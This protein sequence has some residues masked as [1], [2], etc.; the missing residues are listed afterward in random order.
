MI[1]SLF[2]RLRV[3]QFPEVSFTPSLIDGVFFCW[4]QKWPLFLFRANNQL[5]QWVQ[6]LAFFS[7]L[8]K[9]K[10]ERNS[11]GIKLPEPKDVFCLYFHVARLKNW[12]KA[13][14][15]KKGQKTDLPS[16]TLCKLS[17]LL[18]SE[19]RPFLE[20]GWKTL[21]N[22]GTLQEKLGKL[23]HPNLQHFT[24]SV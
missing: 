3:G 21:L 1:L 6:S 7:G 15:A 20:S 12:S 22:E 23:T 13:H 5:A 18:R 24:A 2:V 9:E 11:F 17:I 8:S 19:K 4:F 16:G 14:K 10:A